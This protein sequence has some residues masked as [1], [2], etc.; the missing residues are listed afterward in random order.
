MASLMCLSPEL[1]DEI[2]LYL[3]VSSGDLRS[4]CL[5]C[6]SL[7]RSASPVLY[8]RVILSPETPGWPFEPALSQFL[9]T[10][11]AN[12]GYIKYVQIIK[13]R[14]RLVSRGKSDRG[15]STTDLVLQRMLSRIPN[16]IL[17]TL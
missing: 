8:R 10:H 17:Q 15:I 16:D 9:S 6:K 1:T 2:A 5:T 4:L 13:S 7:N 12:L 3:A 11:N 14:S